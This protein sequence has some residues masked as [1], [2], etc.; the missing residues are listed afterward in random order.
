VRVAFDEQIFLLQ[1]QGGV[2]RYFVELLRHLPTADP[3][4][5]VETPFHR[6][7]NRHAL[8]AF[9]DTRFSPAR[10]AFQPYPQLAAA[11]ARPRRTGRVDLI[12]HTFYHPRFLRDYPGKPKVVTIYDMIPEVMGARGR[13]GSPHMAKRDYVAQAD[14]LLFISAS[15]HEDMINAYGPPS[16]PCVVTHLGVDGRFFKGGGKPAGFPGAYVLF[17]GN[18]SG[19]KDFSTLMDAFSTAGRHLDGVHL[20]CV[21]GGPLS[22]PELA[23]AST[24]GLHGRI[25]QFS[26]PDEQMPGAYANA[27]AFVFPSRY[28]GF[29]LPALESMAAGTPAILAR[30]SSL[31]EVGA[32][33]AVYFTPGDREE[34]ASSLV[35]LLSDE[36]RRADLIRL[37]K[38]R[39]LAFT[40]S[41][42]AQ[43]TAD[44]Y[45]LV[46]G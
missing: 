43:L 45:R 21:G 46:T 19:Y 24:A 26:L 16:A 38:A 36:S 18:R 8:E 5:H 35:H 15:A 22:P 34:L 30:T 32:D 7:V 17:V 13:F 3:S 44:A 33:A 39:A 31:P 27:A 28:E 2:S 12:H 23:D 42:T 14:L 20:V 4:V 25:H 29:G 41:Q 10:G 37:G 1:K 6:V 40:W 9:G 11:A